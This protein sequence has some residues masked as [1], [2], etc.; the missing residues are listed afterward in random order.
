MKI[1]IHYQASYLYETTASFSPHRVRLFPRPDAQVQLERVRFRTHQSANVHYRRDLFDN[2]VGTCFFPEALDRLDFA[3]DIDLCLGERNPFDFLLDAHALDLPFE[4]RTEERAVLSPYLVLQAQLD[5]LPDELKS[6]D[7]RQPTIEA[8]VARNSWI[9]ENITY[10]RREEGDAF[11]PRETLARKKGSCRDSAVLFAEVLRRCGV[12]ARLAS[13]YLWEDDSPDSPRYAANS[14]HAWVEAYLPGAGWTGFDPT[15]GVLC[16]HHFLAAAV[17]LNAADIA[18][19]SG[20]YYG[21]K[22]VA[23]KLDTALEIAR[24]QE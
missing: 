1:A 23:S 18:P 3:L 8:L 13:G 17:G 20:H 6:P 10:E 14:L 19:V 24:V 16:D 9:H 7:S 4:Y 15:N 12:A 22:T 5:E 2:L 21:K 11:P